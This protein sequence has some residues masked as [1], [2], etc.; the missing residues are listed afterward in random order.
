MFD[1]N[2]NVRSMTTSSTFRMVRMDSPAVD[3]SQGTFDVSAFVES[4]GM[5]VQ[6]ESQFIIPKMDYSTNLYVVLIR[7]LQPRIY[8]RW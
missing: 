4:I 5:Y 3:G 8:G 2:D 7:Y 1:D 6:L